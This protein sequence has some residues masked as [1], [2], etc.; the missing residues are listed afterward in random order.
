MCMGAFGSLG[1]PWLASVQHFGL[2]G[3]LAEPAFLHEPLLKTPS[4]KA[5]EEHPVQPFLASHPCFG[6]TRERHVPAELPWEMARARAG[7]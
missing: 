4:G 6:R 3:Y 7:R 1:D 5:L 2:F